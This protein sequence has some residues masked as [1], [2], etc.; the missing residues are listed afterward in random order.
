MSDSDVGRCIFDDEPS[1]PE[2][3]AARRRSDQV[4]ST[5]M[6]WVYAAVALPFALSLLI[7]GWGNTFK[8]GDASAFMAATITVCMVECILQQIS[9]GPEESRR[10][11]I[12][13]IRKSPARRGKQARPISPRGLLISFLLIFGLNMYYAI[14]DRH[15]AYQTVDWVQ[16][17][18]FFVSLLLL[19]AIRFAGTKYDFT[20][21]D[22]NASAENNTR[23]RGFSRHSRA[24]FHFNMGADWFKQGDMGH[25]I[26]ALNRAVAMLHELNDPA[27]EHG[28]PEFLEDAYNSTGQGESAQKVRKLAGE[29]SQRYYDSNS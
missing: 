8:S 25:A 26:P 13:L 11:W 23:F 22:L 15:I 5:I 2:G 24:V 16:I 19:P 10:W 12:Q 29:I 9:E 1:T 27:C 6:I 18:A 3:L 14:S 4:E 21:N 17:L 7:S 28:A 20:V